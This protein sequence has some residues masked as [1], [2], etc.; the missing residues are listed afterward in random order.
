MGFSPPLPFYS[1]RSCEMMKFD[2]PAEIS[3]NLERRLEDF[4][5]R[6]VLVRGTLRKCQG[7]QEGWEKAHRLVGL[8]SGE[9]PG[10]CVLAANA[11]PT[12]KLP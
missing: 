8:I 10:S 3:S 7:T 11:K 6:N 5:Q 2:P 9:K 12:Q 4:V 1:L